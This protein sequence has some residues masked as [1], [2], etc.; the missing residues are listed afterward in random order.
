MKM[1]VWSEIAQICNRIDFPKSATMCFERCYEQI[2]PKYAED[3]QLFAG[4]WMS[5]DGD[6]R[7]CL[8]E[9]STIASNI[10]G[11]YY[12][13]TMLFLLY[14]AIPLRQK[15]RGIGLPENLFWE[16]LQDLRYKLVECY[17]FHGEWGTFV[18]EWYRGFYLCE[19][20]SLGRLQYEKSVFPYKEYKGILKEGDRVYS[21]H[22]PSNGQLLE[23]DVYLSL[24]KAYAFY[25]DEL[26]NGI[27][28]IVCHSWLLYQPLETA[29]MNSRNILRFRNLFDVIENTADLKNGDFWRV[30]Y[31]DFSLQSLNEIEPTTSLQKNLKA[32][33]LDGGT[34]GEGY[35]VLLFDGEKIIKL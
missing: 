13:T 3:L 8:K 22:I 27:L 29:F 10:G 12:S 34:L 32:Y 15:Y 26:K 9:I 20:F 7:N 19:R 18:P 16:T 28:P 2:F 5:V 11:S 1:V 35:G 6:W 4:K 31:R 30:F 24:K 21:C 14:C 17:S 23:T 33:L 25:R